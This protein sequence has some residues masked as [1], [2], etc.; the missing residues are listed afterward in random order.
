MK[1]IYYYLL[2]CVT[3]FSAC[4]LEEDTDTTVV[5]GAP[6]T[7]HFKVDTPAPTPVASRAINDNLLN[8]LYLLVFDENG[9]FLYRSQATLSA[10]GYI[11]TLTQSSVQRTVHFISNYDWSSFSDELVVGQDQTQVIPALQT[12]AL[13]FWQQVILPA[14]ISS[15]S[16]TTTPVAMVRN[17]VKYTLSNAA[18]SLTNVSFGVYNKPSAGTVA[19]YN[20]VTGNFTLG[21]TQPA[22]VTFTTNDAFTTGP[23]YSFERKNSTAQASPTFIIVQATYAGAVCYYKIDLVDSNYN[24]YDMLRNTCFNIQIQS[25]TMAGYSTIAG[26]VASPASN[27]IAA[28]VL[29]QSYPTISD[30]VHVLSVNATTISFIANGQTLNALAIYKT[31]AGVMDNST[32]VV[33]LVQDPN[34]PVITSGFNYNRATGAITGTVNNVPANGAA[35]T[36]TIKVQAGYLSRTIQLMLHAPFQFS[37]ISVSPN[38]LTGAVGTAAALNFTVPPEA[39]YLLPMYVKIT[40]AYLT[41]V[42]NSNI[43]VIYENGLYKYQYKVTATGAQTVNFTTNSATAAETV[44]LDAPLFATGQVSYTNTSGV[45]RFSNVTFSPYRVNFGAGQSVTLAFTT[46][47]AGTFQIHTNNLTPVVGSI[48]GSIYTYT[49]ATAGIQTVAFATNKQNVG[50]MV[51]ITAP[52]YTSY[53]IPLQNQLVTISGTL[54]YGTASGAASVVNVGVVNILD[55]GNVVNIIKTTAT[56]TYTATMAVN[57]GDVL[58]FSYLASDGNTYTATVTVTSATMSSTMKLIH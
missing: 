49:A 21:V 10:G 35:Y 30:G 13:V 34:N 22:G 5:D 48:S 19:P 7:V 38:P 53:Q 4:T 27:N 50:E 29:I 41:P 51:Q 25:V 17:M 37:S 16:F 12:T 56:G 57:I 32:V 26:A 52:S 44:L 1:T 18:T 23:S 6:V 55:K 8:D 40:S 14:G 33:T 46:T 11:A 2:L 45:N 3:M 58:T 28:S 15:T 47:T 9:R 42:Y 24:A 31:V 43:E 20:D 39:A 54:T 36:A